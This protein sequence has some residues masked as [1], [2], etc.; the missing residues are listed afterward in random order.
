LQI[1]VFAPFSLAISIYFEE[2][3]VPSFIPCSLHNLSSPEYTMQDLEM[4]S[5]SKN[6]EIIGSNGTAKDII[7]DRD[8]ADLIRLGK[9]PVLKVTLHWLSN[10]HRD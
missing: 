9:R 6:P 5:V 4:D 3:A 1:S 7:E 10:V 2:A 8:R